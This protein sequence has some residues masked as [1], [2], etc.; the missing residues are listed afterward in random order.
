MLSARPDARWRRSEESLAELGRRV[1]VGERLTLQRL[2]GL[3][4]FAT[5]VCFEN[6][7]PSIERELVRD[8]AEFLPRCL[9]ALRASDLPP[10]SWELIVVD[11]GSLDRT[12]ALV[13]ALIGLLL[14]CAAALV[15]DRLP[16]RRL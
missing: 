16:A 8:G 4:A 3:P 9:T 12:S 6:A 14:G 7:F 2:P 1:R 11:D 13:G 10:D 5:P 15:A